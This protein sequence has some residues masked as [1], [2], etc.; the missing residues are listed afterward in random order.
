MNGTHFTHV[1]GNIVHQVNNK[2]EIKNNFSNKIN[3]LKRNFKTKITIKR[4]DSI[5]KKFIFNMLLLTLVSSNLFAAENYVSKPVKE[6][7]IEGVFGTNKK[8]NNDVK[9]NREIGK[10]VNQLQMYQLE[11]TNEIMKKTK[12]RAKYLG[13]DV[14]SR[15]TKII[16]TNERYGFV[17]KN[18]LFVVNKNSGMFIYKSNYIPKHTRLKKDPVPEKAIKMAVSIFTNKLCLNPK[19]IGKIHVDHMASRGQNRYGRK[20]KE[21]FDNTVVFI[22]RQ[23]NGIPVYG[24]EVRIYFNNEGFMYQSSGLWR[25]LKENK[26][27]EINIEKGKSIVNKIQKD[28]VKKDEMKGIQ[29]KARLVYLELPG[30]LSQK[31]LAPAYLVGYYGAKDLKVH[32]FIDAVDVDKINHK[33]RN[34][35]TSKFQP[36]ISIRQIANSF[37]FEQSSDKK[38]AKI[39]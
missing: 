8:Y 34:L 26:G 38:V 7:S 5:M 13:I 33:Y 18:G 37:M 19:E 16:K 24:S 17:D 32:D 36:L 14:K 25:N 28:L 27:F 11:N 35:P 29:F 15:K 39:N 21:Q 6:Y 22:G 4:G 30:K 10:P 20:D 23:I 31:N 12:L 9:F 1:T 2:Y 3:N